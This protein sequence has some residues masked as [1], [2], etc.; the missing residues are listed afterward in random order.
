[1]LNSDQ[2]SKYLVNPG[3]LSTWSLKEIQ[4]L[5][6]QYPFFQTARL[7]EVKNY[8]AAG[9]F[10]F[11]SK[12]N[13]CAA[14]VTDRRI[15]YELIHPWDTKPAAHEA[16]ASSG[17][18]ERDRKPTLQENIAD[19]LV[20]QLDITRSLNPDETE[21]KPN[22]ALDINKEYGDAVTTE[23]EMAD[24][25]MAEQEITEE[26][27][28]NSIIW[29]DGADTG[30]IL[31]VDEEPSDTLPGIEPD[32]LIDLEDSVAAGPYPEPVEKTEGPQPEA[33]NEGNEEVLPDEEITVS[34]HELINRFIETN[35][36]LTPPAES[37]QPVDISADS[38]KEDDGFLT[39]T[40]AKIYI[41]QGYYAKAIF[42]Y[43]KLLLKF[44]EKSTYFAAQIEAIK[45][46]M[47]KEE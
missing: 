15:L 17:K 35:P 40:L 6:D 47:N 28:D 12:L 45:N 37:T 13:F 1:M 5:T 23:M 32:D 26:G 33:V 11:Q 46:L 16:G 7:L 20:A 36:H 21:L 2:L 41:K 31:S 24:Q 14:Y 38:V 18:A 19:A 3:L 30:A 25:E 4:L 29:L 9:S 44:P 34:S 22:I 43:E 27:T 8:H 39:D 10:D 42:A